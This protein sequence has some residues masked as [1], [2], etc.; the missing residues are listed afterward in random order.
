M[1]FSN[2]VKG[3]SGCQS[4]GAKTVRLAKMAGIALDFRRQILN[5]ASTKIA[6]EDP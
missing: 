5:L 4:G 1:R 3:L 2:A 6:V